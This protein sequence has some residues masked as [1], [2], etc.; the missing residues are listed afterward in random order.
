MTLRLTLSPGPLPSL[1]VADGKFLDGPIMNHWHDVTPH[2]N[3]LGSMLSEWT[4]YP[5]S[6]SQT[7]MSVYSI[8]RAFITGLGLRVNTIS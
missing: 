1:D 2:S 6:K 8:L 5:N 4:S 3:L 7:R